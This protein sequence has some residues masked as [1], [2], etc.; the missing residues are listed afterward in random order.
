M[1]A[2]LSHPEFRTYYFLVRLVAVLGT[3][4]VELQTSFRGHGPE[5]FCAAASL[6][7]RSLVFPSRVVT[8]L[9]LSLS[10]ILSPH[11]GSIASA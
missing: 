10:P 9:S 5:L 2:L 7:L 3:N 4:C 11:I 6:A 1:A 8:R